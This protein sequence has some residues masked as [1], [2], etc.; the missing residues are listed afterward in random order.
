MDEVWVK[1]KSGGGEEVDKE[2][3]GGRGR[4]EKGWE[5]NHLESVNIGVGSSLTASS[6]LEREK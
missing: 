6:L 2:E 1:E 4:G 3:V 5:E